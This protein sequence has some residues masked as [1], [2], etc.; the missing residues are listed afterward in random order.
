MLRDLSF[1]GLSPCRMR[2]SPGG[3]LPSRFRPGMAAGVADLILASV[4]IGLRDAFLFCWSLWKTFS[5]DLGMLFAIGLCAA[6]P[7][8]AGTFT[9]KDAVDFFGLG[10][11]AATGPP[12][13][14]LRSAQSSGS[15]P[16]KLKMSVKISKGISRINSQWHN[17]IY[18]EVL[19][20]V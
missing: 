1:K 15:R 5:S 11:D 9:A 12:S 20:R 6:D 16:A 4:S 14:L 17:N 3:S 10:G 8:I 13:F 19:Q 18:A 2:S 7:G